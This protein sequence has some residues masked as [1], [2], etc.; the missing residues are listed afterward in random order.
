[1]VT[2]TKERVCDWALKDEQGLTGKQKER[3][4]V[5][6]CTMGAGYTV[7][8]E[9]SAGPDITGSGM[10]P[11]KLTLFGEQWGVKRTSGLRSS[12]SVSSEPT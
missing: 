2:S 7:G 11:T 5:L 10:L 3:R 12:L 8:Q 4:R 1:M 9:D 6:G